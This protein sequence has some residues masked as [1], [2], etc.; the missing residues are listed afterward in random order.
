FAGLVVDEY[1]Q[2]VDVALVGGE[3]FYVVDDAG[4]LR[5]IES[6]HVDRQVLD[7]LQEMVKGHEDLI[8]EGTMKMIGQEDIFTKAAI[9]T[10]LQNMDA[11]FD[12]LLQ[13]GL[14]EDMRTYLGMMGF[15]VVINVH[16]D[17]LRVEQPGA[18]IEPGEEY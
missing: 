13:S 15:R 11:Q 2:A 18:G 9:E 4:F 3:S 1:D 7:H 17:I 14:P 6:E 5:H 8:S 12:A 10:S 16:G